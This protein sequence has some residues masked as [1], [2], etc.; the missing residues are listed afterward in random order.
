MK[1]PE[2]ESWKD[3]VGFE[4]RYQVSNLGRVKSLP[5]ARRFS[6]LFLKQTARKDRR[7]VVN[8]TTRRDGRWYQVTKQVHW[9]VLAAFVGKLPKGKHGC[10]NDG[11]CQ[12]N[13]KDNLRY[14][15]PLGNIHDRVKHDQC[16]RGDRNGMA[17]LTADKVR[18]IKTKLA[19][20]SDVGAV[21]IENRVSRQTISA[22]KSGKRWRHV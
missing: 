13:R 11:D 9:L 19:D 10:H 18:A 5:N 15:T 8:L 12:N 14:D 22:I 21:A 3:V 2:I 6:E 1:P 20:G 16:N 4:G 17:I 7:F